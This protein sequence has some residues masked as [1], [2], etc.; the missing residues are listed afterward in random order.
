MVARHKLSKEPAILRKTPEL[1]RL[2]EVYIHKMTRT[3]SLRH[4]CKPFPEGTIARTT[5]AEKLAHASVSRFVLTKTKELAPPEEAAIL[6]R[7]MYH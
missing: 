4:K 5:Q 6:S 7:V 2:T 3:T 1:Q